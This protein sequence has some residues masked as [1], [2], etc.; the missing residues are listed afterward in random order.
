VIARRRL[1]SGP[2]NPGRISQRDRIARSTIF[3][4]TS[5]KLA[6]RQRRRPPPN[7]IQV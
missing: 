3:I 6:P 1:T 2:S 5:A 4:S 7:G